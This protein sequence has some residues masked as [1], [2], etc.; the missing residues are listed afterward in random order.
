MVWM[1]FEDVVIQL[2]GAVGIIKV[3]VGF[4]GI[5]NMVVQRRSGSGRRHEDN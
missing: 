5:K 2:G 3:V 1:E 4:L